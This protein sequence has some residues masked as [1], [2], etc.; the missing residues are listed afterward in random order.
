MEDVVNERDTCLVAEGGGEKP[1][2]KQARD[3]RVEAQPGKGF[4]GG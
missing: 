1:G 2:A 4:V 3:D